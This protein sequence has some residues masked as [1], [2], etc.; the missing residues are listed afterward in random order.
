MDYNAKNYTEQGGEKTVIG[1]IL[2]FA[3][4]AGIH[5]MP[6][7][8]IVPAADTDHAG[9]V[10][11][12]DSLDVDD[13]GTLSAQPLGGVKIGRGLYFNQTD[14]KLWC[15]INRQIPNVPE[16]DA[17][18]QNT[19]NT[20]FQILQNMKIFGQMLSDPTGGA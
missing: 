9:G 7:E 14:G 20:L 8:G 4:G 6:G 13:D 12:G 19:F 5:G 3:P 1:G 2:E 16:T 10:V 11:V 18:K 17:S 15:M